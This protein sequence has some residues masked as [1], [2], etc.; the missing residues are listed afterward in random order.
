ML[1]SCFLD[2]V[3]LLSGYPS[4]VRVCIYI[5]FLHIVTCNKVTLIPTNGGK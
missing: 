5:Y 4:C 3:H 1:Y 2:F